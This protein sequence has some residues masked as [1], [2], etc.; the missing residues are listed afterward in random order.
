M[1]D[2]V[3]DIVQRY[4]DTKIRRAGQGN[5]SVKCPFHTVKDGTPF[6]VNV[7][8]GLFHCFTCH[9]AGSIPTMLA[10]LGVDQATI[11][12]E[13]GPLRQ[14][15]KDAWE[16]KKHDRKAQYSSGNPFRAKFVLSESLISA[17]DWC[18]TPLIESDFDPSWLKYLQIGVDLRNRRVTYPV[19]DIYGNLAGFVGGRTDRSQQP[20]YRVY[21]GQQQ[22]YDGSII[23]SDY[24]SW[25]DE[26]Y[27]GYEFRSHDYLWNYDKVYP[28]LLFGKEPEQVIIVEGFKAC[29]WVLQCGF[30]N[31][32]ALMGSSMSYRQKE[33]LL[34]VDAR[35]VLLLDNNTAGQDGTYKIGNTLQ[36]AVPTVWVATYPKGA[37]PDCQ[38]DDLDPSIVKSMIDEANPF[39]NW[40]RERNLS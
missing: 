19:R 39:R 36:K 8:L 7:E 16:N 6:S 3:I 5:I 23:P 34:R 11:E 33:L 30:K 37:G 13:V 9:V 29:I 22:A 18:P 2:V 14:A 10:M 15:L 4:V 17:Y 40:K 12:A 21:A 31:T 26:E 28:R 38:P 20:K 27:P 25:F 24:G 35:I 32:I 1:R